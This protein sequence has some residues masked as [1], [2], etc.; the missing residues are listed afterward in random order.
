MIFN[1]RN[2][3]LNKGG[4]LEGLFI[5]PTPIGNLEDITIR[6]LKVLKKVDLIACED[7]RVSRKLLNRYNIKNK[8][9][10]YHKFNYKSKIPELIEILKSGHSIAV[11][12]DAGMPG[13]SD[14]GFEIINA[15][16]NENIEVSVL[17]GASASIMALVSSGISSERFTFI[18]FLPEKSTK[19]KAE[20]ENL[21]FYKETLIFYEAP[22]RIKEMLIDLLEIFGD[23]KVSICRELT[24]LYEEIIRDNLVNIVKKLEDL[25]IKGEFVI[26]VEGYVE[27]T[28]E[29]N[30]KEELSLLISKG[31]S[32]KEAVKIITK[33]YNLR[34]N[35]VYEISLEL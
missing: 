15:C 20:L 17:P 29:I 35:E 25:T 8:L 33:E 3:L 2:Y 14:P 30:I 23:R 9:T 19:R 28:K 16:I 12:S 4:V 11:I 6:T 32:K 18:G 22:H 31:Y 1:F 21:K 27:D 13:I 34:K 26:V 5:C 7:T 24:K 10:S